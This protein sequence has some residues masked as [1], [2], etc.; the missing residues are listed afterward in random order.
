MPLTSDASIPADRCPG[1]L[2]LVEAADG[3]LARVRLPG[4]FVTAGQLRALARL[5]TTL[6]DGRLELTSRANVQLRALPPDAGPRLTA[7]L[8]AA[9]LLPSLEHD[10]VRN[11]LASPLAGLDDGP[12]RPGRLAGPDGNGARG[13][14]ESPAGPGFPAG[15]GLPAEPDLPGGAS[16]PDGVKLSG[17]GALPDWASLSGRAGLPGLTGAPNEADLPGGAELLSRPGVPGGADLEIV[18]RALDAGLCGR[19]RLSELS[20]RFLFAIDDGRGD[21]AGLGADVVAVMRADG[22]SADRAAVNGLGIGPADVAR[23]T[24]A[25][26]PGAPGP[27]DWAQAVATVMLAFAEEFLDERAAARSGDPGRDG[28]AAGRRDWRVADLPG[29][30]EQMRIAVA[31]RFGLAPGQAP[32][33]AR[34]RPAA[35]GAAS[36]AGRPV[37]V[38]ARPGAAGEEAAAVVVLAPLGRLTA[39][40]AQWLAGQVRGRPARVTPWRSIVLPGV[41][42]AGGVLKEAAAAGLGINAAS[43]WLNVTACAGRPGCSR[44]RADVQQDAAGLADRWPGRIVHVS[45]CERHCGRPATTEIDVTATSEGYQVAGA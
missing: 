16:L 7:G 5:A 18:V 43:P 34:G 26:G 1:V 35:A 8:S 23:I 13:E 10:R 15:A 44:A 14:P 38:V 21:V 36:A 3:Y 2:R 27:R 11:I 30:A 45:G 9:G 19:P 29:A 24:A 28:P 32:S 20:G 25:P 31:G 41:A 17:G 33:P 6:G 37:G 4:G 42:D 40:Q 22:A 12:P 39:E